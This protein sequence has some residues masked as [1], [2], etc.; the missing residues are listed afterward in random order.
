M[1]SET[2][3]DRQLQSLLDELHRSLLQAS[4]DELLGEARSA[5]ID[6]VENAKNLRQRFLGA[7]QRYQKRKF[8]A[9][10]QAYASQTE[11]LKQRSYQLPV[12]A[13]EQRALLQIVV[14]QQSQ[15]GISLT[16]K[17]RDFES[18]PDSDLPGLLDELAALGLLPQR[19]EPE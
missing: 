13:A 12:S 18:L 1:S 5:G 19:K 16:A 9:A 10:K 6:P 7:A 14:A 2:R 4:D 11:A 17:F 3:H 15:V 8:E